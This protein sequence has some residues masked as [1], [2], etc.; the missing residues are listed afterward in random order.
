M[1]ENKK[2]SYVFWIPTSISIIS[3]CLGI[4]NHKQELE[5]R[6]KIQAINYK[7]QIII[8][9]H[10]IPT[11]N[12]K[13]KGTFTGP[14]SNDSASIEL[15][16]LFNFQIQNQGNNTAKIITRIFTDTV[17]G[18]EYLRNRIFDKDFKFDFDSSAS[19]FYTSFDLRPT[20]TDSI[21]INNW[22]LNVIKDN[23]FAIH[24]LIFY[25][26]DLGDLYDTYYQ[27]RFR[28][29]EIAGNKMIDTVNHRIDIIWDKPFRI[30]NLL[31]N[32]DH[33]SSYKTYQ[34]SERI[35]VMA[36]L[37]NLAKKFYK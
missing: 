3:L 15:S 27:A 17:T 35:K 8:T 20:S 14:F 26:N 34:E 13:I 6:K 5:S 9:Q 23:I 18:E 37:K 29:L 25:E 36:R 28:V 32:V 24:L 22:K 4:C 2:K 16:I 12:C 1:E 7:P 10:K 31:E 21:L 30:E 11:I 33:Y 19:R